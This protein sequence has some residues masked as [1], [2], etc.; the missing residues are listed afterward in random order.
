M[1]V[2]SLDHS[3]LRVGKPTY[4]EPRLARRVWSINVLLVEDDAADT[5][6]IL[7]VLK[8]HPDVSAAR[9]S[10]TPDDAL[11]ELADG[12]SRPDLVLLDIH[13]PRIDGFEFLRRMRRIPEMADV[14]V[15]FLTS[16]RL[17]S[18]VAKAWRSSPTSY[19]IK[20]ETHAELQNRLDSVIRRTISGTRTR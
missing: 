18:D 7:D 12:R 1:S 15:V 3:L 14:P 16:S 2:E 5:A 20:P 8:R 6:L 13:M 17:P 19:V 11:R 9:A 10:D 4:I